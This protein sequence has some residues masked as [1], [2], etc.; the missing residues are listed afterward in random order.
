MVHGDNYQPTLRTGIGPAGGRCRERVS[1]NNG[2]SFWNSNGVAP[3][4]AVDDQK[5]PQSETLQILQGLSY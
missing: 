2:A 4:V 3:N 1:P 5:S